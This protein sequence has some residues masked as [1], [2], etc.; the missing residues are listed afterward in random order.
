[1]LTR[2]LTLRHSV[3]SDRLD[4]EA[5]ALDASKLL[6]DW[7]QLERDTLLERALFEFATYGRVRFHHRSVP[8][9]LAAKRLDTLLGR[10]VPMKTVR[11]ILFAHTA[12]GTRVVKPSLRPTA[13]WL[14]LWRAEIFCEVLRCEPEVLLVQGD[15]QSLTPLQRCEVLKAYVHRYGTGGW[16]GLTVPPVQAQRFACAELDPTVRMLWSDGIENLEVRGL[17]LDLIGTG[18]LIGCAEIA[19]IVFRDEKASH[20]ERIDA[21]TALIGLEDARLQ[22]IGSSLVTQPD[23]WPTLLVRSATIA[24]FPTYLDVH[25]VCRILQRAPQRADDELSW[26]LPHLITQG[27]LSPPAID[28]LRAGLTT[29]IL[30]GTDWQADRWPHVQPTRLDLVASLLATCN[31]Q[32]REGVR[33]AELFRSS[34][35]TSRFVRDEARDERSNELQTHLATAS[36][37]Q[38]QQTFWADDGFLQTLHP[39]T[40]AWQRLIQATHYGGISLNPDKDRSWVLRY[41][42]DRSKALAERKMMLWAAMIQVKPVAMGQRETL[43]ELESYVSDAPELLQLIADRAKPAGHDERARELEEQ[44]RKSREEKQ[45]QDVH[46]RASWTKFWQEV[47]SAPDEVFGAAQADNT[48]WNLWRAMQRSGNDSRASGWNRRFI[49]QQFGRVTADRLRLTLQRMWRKEKPTLRSERPPEKKNTFLMRWQLGLA[50][51]YAEAED[52]HWATKLTDSEARLAARFA[53]IELNGFPA[54]LVGR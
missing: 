53:P 13:A 52:S 7:T 31:R 43:Q 5:P 30:E 18:K 50:A 8:E 49:E 29:L 27:H 19:H 22:E 28:D 9:Y 38:R 6:P 36:P 42:N 54:W 10:G 21:L 48:A 16:R 17:L 46:A 24:L 39:I 35:L 25:Q 33:S 12:Q 41:L 37:A 4:A 15:P 32:F 11:R 26:R 47:A 2:K 40:D 51:L 3:E 23:L 14:S 45:Q 1:L 44:S 34:V 20:G